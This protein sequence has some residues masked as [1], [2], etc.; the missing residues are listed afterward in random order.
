MNYNPLE[1]YFFTRLMKKRPIC[2]PG[3]GQ[4]ITGLGHVE[5][6]ASAMANVIGKETTKGQI[7]NIQDTQSVS[8]ES[9][10]LLC[11]T[12]MGQDPSKVKI[13]Y[14]DKDMF[15][16]SGKKAFPMREQHFFCS[17]KRVIIYVI[18]SSNNALYKFIICYKVDKAMAD[19]EW[20]PKYDMLSGLKD[21]YENDF[22]HK[23]VFLSIF[24][25]FWKQFLLMIL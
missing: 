5:D 2:I 4:H 15:D 1:E 20:S 13:K 23:M 22:L 3:H 7:Y 21:S 16:F 25:M 12:A 6:L 18:F 11:A 9:L 24:N 14:Y 19:L 17:G 8:F 10:A